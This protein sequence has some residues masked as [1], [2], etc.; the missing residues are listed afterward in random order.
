M[1]SVAVGDGY[2]NRSCPC[3]GGTGRPYFRFGE[4]DIDACPNC[5]FV[6]VRNIP[7]E[8]FLAQHYRRYCG[9]DAAAYVPEKRRHKRLKNWWFAQRLKRIAGERRRLLEIGYAHGN[10][11]K[12]LQRQDHFEFEGIDFSEAPLPHLKALGLDVSVASL[13]DKNYPDGRFDLVVGLHVLEHVQNPVRFMRE[14]HRVLSPAGRIYFQV[15]CVTYWRARL[16]GTRWKAFGP[17]EHLWYFSAKAMR[18]FLVG[19]G[20]RVLSAHSL[21]HRA[22]LTVTAEKA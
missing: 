3:C 1:E 16:A 17:P 12:A 21:S 8:E 11:L 10:L 4:Y 2:V 19:C 15:P 13:Q 14:V 20:F 6:Y 22:H 5:R 9:A 7:S 18:R